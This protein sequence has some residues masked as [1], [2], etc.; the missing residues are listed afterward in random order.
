MGAP[1]PSRYDFRG[2]DTSVLV[3]CVLEHGEGGTSASSSQICNFSHEVKEW[4]SGRESAKSIH[5]FV[6]VVVVVVHQ[7]PG[8]S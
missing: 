5:Q 8:V 2:V 6:V 1:P 4:S 3:S 7:L